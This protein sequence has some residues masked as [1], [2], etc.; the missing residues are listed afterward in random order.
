MEEAK[1]PKYVRVASILR[2]RITLQKYPV[3]SSIPPEPVL[4]E[5]FKVS[6]STIRNAIQLLVNEGLLSVKQGRGTTVVAVNRRTRFDNVISFSEINEIKISHCI[7]HIDEVALPSGEDATF[8][9][10]PPHSFVYRLQRISYDIEDTPVG[11]LTN[12]LSQELVP[13]FIKY[14]GKFEDLYSFL[15][16]K[17]GIIYKKATE[18]VYAEAAG[19][20]ESQILKIPLGTPLLSSRRIA[21]CNTGPLE[22]AYLQRVA[23]RYKLVFNMEN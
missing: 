13:D 8:L 12:Y 6:R 17:Y 21:Y 9:Q 11:I 23:S 14:D 15:Q 5:E 19:L 3:N 1:I 4:Q 20:I 10:I 7:S 16:E 18:S 2:K 22:C